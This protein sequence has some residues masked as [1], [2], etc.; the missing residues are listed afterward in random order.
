VSAGTATFGGTLTISLGDLPEAHYQGTGVATVNGNIFVV[1]HGV[2][3][4]TEFG[5]IGAHM[6]QIEIGPNVWTGATVVPVTDPIG[7]AAN[8]ITAVRITLTNGPGTLAWPD[9]GSTSGNVPLTQNTLGLAGGLARVCIVFGGPGCVLNLPLALG[10]THTSGTSVIGLGVGGQQVIAGLP[11]LISV[12]NAP[13]TVLSATALDQPDVLPPT[14]HTAG[15]SIGVDC[16]P[17]APITQKC[18]VSKA[19]GFRHGPLSASSTVNLGTVSSPAVVQFV[20]PGQ[21]TTNITATSSLKLQL[22]SRMRF[23]LVPEPGLV[24]LLGTGVAGLA[25]LGRRR[26]RK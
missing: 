5:T 2:A 3:S 6:S 11:L 24:L 7:I 23:R 15:T 4:N 21:V 19:T 14:V 16:F 25:V 20:T 13:W 26:M 22:L 10:T 17:G 12:D 8:G 9:T 1:G 18:V